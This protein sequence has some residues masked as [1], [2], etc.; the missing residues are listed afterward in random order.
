M[1]NFAA[2]KEWRYDEFSYDW[3]KDIFETAERFG[4]WLDGHDFSRDA[5]GRQKSEG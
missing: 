5:Q 1:H 3:R 4:G 2:T